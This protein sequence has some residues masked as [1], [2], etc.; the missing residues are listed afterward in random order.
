MRVLQ[1]SIDFITN[2]GNQLRP[3]DE[4]ERRGRAVAAVI[5]LVVLAT[6]YYL[7]T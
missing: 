4:E 6:L 7:F 3:K 2:V 1:S 5:V